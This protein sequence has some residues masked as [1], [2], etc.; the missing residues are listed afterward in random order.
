MQLQQ[1]ECLRSEIP[2]A[3][4]WLPVLVIHIR[5]QVKTI[6]SQS[7]KFNKIAKILNSETL[8]DTLHAAHL[9]GLLGKMYKYEMDPARTV[10]ATELT[11][12][13]GRTQ[14]GWKDGRTAGR[15]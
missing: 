13:V 8:Q 7:Y 2:P 14:D 10:G 5:S 9:L 1:W 3:V 11:C 12:D 4:P 15:T 6:Q